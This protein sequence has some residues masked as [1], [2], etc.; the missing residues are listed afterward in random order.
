MVTSLPK[1]ILWTRISFQSFSLSAPAICKK[2]ISLTH[3]LSHWHHSIFPAW[4]YWWK[5]AK[6][7]GS[8]QHPNWKPQNVWRFLRKHQA[9]GEPKNIQK[10]GLLE[11]SWKSIGHTFRNEW[12]WNLM[13]FVHPKDFF[14]ETSIFWRNTKSN[15]YFLHFA[16]NFC[17]VQTGVKGFYDQACSHF[18]CLHLHFWQPAIDCNSRVVPHDVSQSEFR[19]ILQVS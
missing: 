11:A 15:T 8:S 4:W 6:N 7:Q 10:N 2:L 13:Q 12:I 17:D 9:P 19:S 1:V 18:L 5:E 16:A 14:I 3:L